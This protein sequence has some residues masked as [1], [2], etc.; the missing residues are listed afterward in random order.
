MPIV[1][2]ARLA[3]NDGSFSWRRPPTIDQGDVDVAGW[4]YG[5]SFAELAGAEWR[6]SPRGTREWSDCVRRRPVRNCRPSEGRVFV[7]LRI[8][9]YQDGFLANQDPSQTKELLIPS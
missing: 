7:L 2:G 8:S 4:E 6:L 9:C 3:L 1:L 5:A